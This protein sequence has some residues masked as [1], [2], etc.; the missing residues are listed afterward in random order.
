MASKKSRR[1]SRKSGSDQP[2]RQTKKQIA[3]G[4]KQARQNRIIYISVAA[5]AVVVIAILAFGLIS[6]LVLKPG[7][8]VATVNGTKIPL[9]DYQ[10]MLTYRRYN[11]H[12]TINQIQSTLDSLNPEDEQSDLLRSI[13]EQ[14]LQQTQTSLA[15]ASEDVLDE[16]IEDELIREEANQ[17]GLTVTDAEVEEA[18]FG[19]LEQALSQPAQTVVTGTVPT[20]TPIPQEQLEE[21]YNSILS[22]IGIDDSSFR[23]LIA[24]G[25]LREKLQNHLADQVE[26]TGLVAQV[27]LIAT[28][29]Q[30]DAL[31]A[32][33][34][35]E[36]GEDF[37]IVAQE[38]SSDTVSL[39][40]GGDLGWV[41]PDQLSTRYGPEVEQA[42]FDAT[43]DQVVLVEGQDQYYLVLV[44]DRDENG[45]L[46]ESVLLANQNTALSDWLEEQLQSPEVEIERQLEESQIPE[47]PFVVTS[48][49]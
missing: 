21:V 40:D 49:Q 46:P 48:F 9:D 5:L 30:E 20:A 10:D 39:E 14:Q 33:A 28:D 35:I 47:D 36:G 37:A 38:V 29:T 41:T 42:A 31:E 2:A 17:L 3:I 7:Q 1:S 44:R 22:N 12:T 15:L 13:Y 16:L 25:L 34:R 19:D 4:R 11:L 26:T 45:P 27:S 18:I 32:Q 24:R 23:S 43:L 6:E 8:P